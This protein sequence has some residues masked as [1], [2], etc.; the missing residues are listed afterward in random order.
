[1]HYSSINYWTPG[2]TYPRSR[3]REPF[4]R[5]RR[6]LSIALVPKVSISPDII[7]TLSPRGAVCALALRAATVTI[8]SR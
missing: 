7:V 2:W 1:M 6:A 8:L 5:R 3:L 4:P